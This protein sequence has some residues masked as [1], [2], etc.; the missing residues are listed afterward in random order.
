MFP[1]KKN[2]REFHLIPESANTSWQSKFIIFKGCSWLIFET[3]LST[4]A[5]V[6]SVHST[7]SNGES[8]CCSIAALFFFR[9]LGASE[10]S[11]ALYFVFATLSLVRSLPWRALLC[12][13]SFALCFFFRIFFLPLLYSFSGFLSTGRHD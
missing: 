12:I 9:I 13:V 2:R 4:I 10:P 5:S 8:C 11:N 6:S 1:G 3:S 7:S